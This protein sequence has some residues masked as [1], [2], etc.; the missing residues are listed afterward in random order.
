MKDR[1]DLLRDEARRIAESAWAAAREHAV[2][3]ARFAVA[4][5]VRLGVTGLS[6]SGKTVFVTSLVQNMLL[7]RTDRSRLPML[8]LVEQDQLIDVRVAAIPGVPMFPL[9][10]TAAALLSGGDHWPESTRGLSG[11]RL[12]IEY[13]P[14]HWLRQRLAPS[15]RLALE[16]ID[17]PGEW[18]LDLPMAGQDF[19]S[20]SQRQLVL[21][22]TEPRA[23]LARDFLASVDG[24]NPGSWF[25][26]TRFGDC[27]GKF[28]AY[29]QACRDPAHGLSNFQP[30]HLVAPYE[31]EQTAMDMAFFP[32]P[33]MSG[34][35]LSAGTWGGELARRYRAYVDTLVI[36]FAQ[37]H[38]HRL[39]RQIILVDV[40]AALQGGRRAFDDM[41]ATLGEI[42]ATLNYGRELPFLRLIRPRI[43]SVVIAA[44]KADHVTADQHPALQKVL[45]DAVAEPLR[46]MK[47]ERAKVAFCALSAIRCTEDRDLSKQDEPTTYGLWG[48][49]LGQREHRTVRVGVIPPDI[50]RIADW[51][52]QRWSVV[53]FGLPPLEGQWYPHLN[54]DEAVQDLM[55]EAVS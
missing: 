44:S 24:L 20:W 29:L 53:R 10:R 26:A 33:E 49:I 4:R 51:S 2:A 54:L 50:A 41:R 5:T 37:R 32:L 13:R 40:L 15:A 12:E 46:H 36:P 7:A 11:L 34:R 45:Q 48:R 31:H 21:M 14:R 19:R 42:L 9:E 17:Y 25:D 8:G 6:R 52:G 3:A 16:I 23:T 47:A 38:F 43:G 30:G 18:L 22:R 55:P 27:M 39:D 35:E 1:I 28:L